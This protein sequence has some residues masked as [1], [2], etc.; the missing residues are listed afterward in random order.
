MA[1]RIFG[2]ALLVLGVAGCPAQTSAPAGPRADVPFVGQ[3]EFVHVVL[4]SK[5]PVLVKFTASWC[6]PCKMVQPVVEQVAAEFEGKALVRQVDVDK[7]PGLGRAYGVEGVPTI[8]IFQD[9]SVQN[10]H[11][12]GGISR[13]EL[14][15]DLQSLLPKQ[16]DASL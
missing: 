15:E 1:L 4:D 5:M 10:R 8:L 11:V 13:D 2:L 3:D 9:G 12:G 14:A 6:G 7:D 16:D